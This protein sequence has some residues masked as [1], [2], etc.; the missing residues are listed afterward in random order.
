MIWEEIQSKL[1]TLRDN[2]EKLDQIPQGSYEEFVSDFRNVDAALH[3]LQTN[4]QS[5]IDV[6]SYATAK[7][8]LGAPSTSR[9]RATP[10]SESIAGS[11]AGDTRL[12]LSRLCILTLA[13]IAARLP[14][15]W[16]QTGGFLRRMTRRKRQCV[17][18]SRHE[19]LALQGHVVRDR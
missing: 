19:A 1:A 16:I 6:G 9:Y 15:R 7:L 2:F 5:L 4:I 18:K 8:G 3:R 17:P 12:E 13:G 14:I 10:G 11:I